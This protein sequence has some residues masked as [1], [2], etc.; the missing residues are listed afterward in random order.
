MSIRFVTFVLIVISTYSQLALGSIISNCELSSGQKQELLD[1][2]LYGVAPGSGE[3]Y[4]RRAY[5]LAYDEENLVPKWVAWHAKPSYRDTP[6]RKSRWKKF[7]TDPELN[8]VEDEDYKYW[9]RS[10]YNFARGHLVPYYISGGDRDNDGMDAEYEDSLKI[11]DMDDACTVFEVNYLSNVAPQY[12]NKFNGSGG[13]WYELETRTRKMIEDGKEFYIIAGTVFL[14]N[15]PI[16][17]IGNKSKAENSWGIGVPHGFFK[18][19]IDPIA[20]QSISYLFDHSA[21]VPNGCS[22]EDNLEAC[23]VDI[24][25]IEVLTGLNF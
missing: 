24:K 3:L 2:H 18:I 23:I 25:D 12:H 19:V 22:L 4:V 21:D 10:E 8:L 15:Q 20:N 5:V 1:E 14:N 7:W 16:Q 11:E 17:K 6:K 9:H 13:L